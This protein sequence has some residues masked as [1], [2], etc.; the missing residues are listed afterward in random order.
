MG[1][2]GISR[3][4]IRQRSNETALGLSTKDGGWERFGIFKNRGDCVSYV[5]TGGENQ[6]A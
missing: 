5:G 4:P 2:A 6:P 3:C 1:P